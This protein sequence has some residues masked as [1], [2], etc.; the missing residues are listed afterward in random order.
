MRYLRLACLALAWLGWSVLLGGCVAT[1]VEQTAIAVGIAADWSEGD[2]VVSVQLAKVLTPDQA[3]S[4]EGP[5]FVVMSERGQ[6]PSEAAR[7]VTLTLPR[8]PL[9][10]HAST[11]VLGEDLARR[12]ITDI[13]DF[14]TRN[15]NLRKNT[16]MVMTR[17]A[18]PEE[19]FKIDTPL[20][21]HSAVA[22]RRILETQEEQTGIYSPV[23]LGDF[24]SNLAAAGIEPV[25]P[26][27]RIISDHGK[28]RLKIEGTAVFRG[29]EWVGELNE[30]ESRGLRLLS[31]EQIR[32]GLLVVPAPG[33][34]TRYVTIE[35]ISSQATMKPVF[36]D[37]QVRMMAKVEA[38]GNFYDQTSSQPL[39]NLETIDLLEELVAGQMEKEMYQAIRKAQGYQADI[40][41]WGRLLD[42]N[43]PEIWQQVEP[44]WPEIFAAMPV[45]IKVNFSLRRTYLTD[46]SFIIK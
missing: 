2:Y 45:D 34:E 13:V 41:G 33:D 37:G 29:P 1:E 16:L 18:K 32:G 4:V 12:G 15:P 43:H 8:I 31:E 35:V 39:L 40:F 11:L 36:E 28:E 7:R 17:G 24:V 23:T 38:D 27:V 44:D 3:G 14:L 9:W 10:F 30:T 6:T 22:I 26:Q 46:R 42:I 25:L 5:L 19:V 21:P 20:E